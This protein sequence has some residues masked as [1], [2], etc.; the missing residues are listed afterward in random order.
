[1]NTAKRF[2]FSLSALLILSGTALA[3]PA[4]AR[5]GSDS[6][7]DI[8]ESSTTTTGSADD[9]STTGTQ[10]ETEV[11]THGGSLA[12]QFKIAA[13]AKVAEKKSQVKE[14]TEEHRQQA[15]EARKTNLANRMSNAVTQAQK[16]KDVFDKIYARVKDFYTNKSLNVTDYASLTANVDT[17]Q[18]AAADSISALK[19]L[20]V[21]VDCSSQT[22]ATSVSAF[23]T[24]VGNTRDS[25]KTYRAAIVKLITA[26]KG[27][28]T[29][30]T[31]TDNSTDTTQTNTGN[32]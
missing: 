1:M 17:T 5:G 14:Q 4:Y 25:L 22:V 18:A 23:Q 26:I 31:K 30:T 21:S 13:Q 19:T 8:A 2:L 29:S 12:E 28:S 3:L 9:N 15:C 16:H 11:E 6:P 27:A 32:Q 24:A 20:D 10:T 7:Q